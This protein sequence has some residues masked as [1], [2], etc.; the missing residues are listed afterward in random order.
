[1]KN[2][3]LRKKFLNCLFNA[4]SSQIDS[5]MPKETGT[6]KKKKEGKIQSLPTR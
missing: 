1:M 3:G 5:I 6:A 4:L 2:F